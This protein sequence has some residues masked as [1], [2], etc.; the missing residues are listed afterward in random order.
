MGKIKFCHTC[1]IYRPERTFHCNF[2][3]NCVNRF[4]HH[5]TWLATCVGSRSY[6]YFVLFIFSLM[7]MELY[8]FGYGLS[9]LFLLI[10]SIDDG[11]SNYENFA[12]AI[13]AY[14]TLVVVYFIC[15]IVFGFVL[16]LFIYHLKIIILGQ[17]TYA[18][19]KGHY[20]DSLFNPYKKPCCQS[21]LDII[22]PRI[23]T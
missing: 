16:K 5:C 2:C 8:T 4:D 6:P 13:K 15:I 19:L 23:P 1:M 9:Q 20:K 14:P 12:Q 10:F 7:L 18:N 3:G 17:S 22:W 11:D 21:F